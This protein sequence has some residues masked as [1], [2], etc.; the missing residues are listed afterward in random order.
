MSVCSLIN[1]KDKIDIFR[2]TRLFTMHQ[3]AK[4]AKG[5]FS[6]RSMVS[7][8]RGIMGIRTAFGSCSPTKS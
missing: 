2:L 1:N 4:S 8:G 7:S 3:F 6:T 5:C